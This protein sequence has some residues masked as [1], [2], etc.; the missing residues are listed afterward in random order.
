M[1]E[2]Q[3]RKPEAGRPKTED[4]KLSVRLGTIATIVSVVLLAACSSNSSASAEPVR[5]YAIGRAA[6][7]AE[8]TSWSTEIGPDGAELPPGSGTVDAGAALYAAKCASCH[9][10]KGEGIAPAYPAL[11]GRDPKGENFVFATDWKITRTIGNYWPYAT[12]VFDY[13]R[14]AMPLTQ[15]GSLSNDEVYALTAYLLAANQVIP[16]NS[17]LDAA[18]LRAVKMPYV[19]RF[20]RDDRKGGHEVK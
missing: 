3:S 10:P 14:R 15:P 18:R 4:H 20:V 11:I 5:H 8:I 17:T 1:N 19:D 7:P 13:V 6:T 9:G 2:D 16:M 12:T